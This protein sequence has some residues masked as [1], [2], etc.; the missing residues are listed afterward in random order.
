V[1]ALPGDTIEITASAINGSE[2]FDGS[3][4]Y[5]VRESWGVAEVL[6]D[7]S[8]GS[9]GTKVARIV[10][11]TDRQ[12]TKI[13]IRDCSYRYQVAARNI[14]AEG[15]S[16][17][18][19]EA[20][21]ENIDGVIVETLN[22]N[23]A[24]GWQDIS[25]E[26]PTGDGLNTIYT[27]YIVE[28]NGSTFGAEYT[29]AGD[30]ILVTNRNTK[31][32]I[33]KTWFGADGVTDLTDSITD[34]TVSLKVY[35]RVYPP[36]RGAYTGEGSLNVLTGDN[37]VYGYPESYDN[38]RQ[39]TSANLR[40]TYQNIKAGSD[41]R[42]TISS[43]GQYNTDPQKDEIRINGQEV[44]FDYE[45]RNTAPYYIR[46]LT[47][48][49]VEEDIVFSGRI[50]A[51]PF[52]PV[53]ILIEVLSEPI[54]PELLATIEAGEASLS[55]E[56]F[57]FVPKEPFS[58]SGITASAGQDVWTGLINNLPAAGTYNGQS[59]EYAYYFEEIVGE[60]DPYTLMETLDE[61]STG[62]VV[63]LKNKLK[64]GSLKVTKAV[65]PALGRG[66]R[67]RRPHPQSILC[68]RWV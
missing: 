36:S 67:C 52:H 50:A 45:N 11:P 18:L 53:N 19:S 47:L 54:D 5:W 59:V 12:A 20:E 28:E 46:T 6:F 1:T 26:Y 57:T 42:I 48:E 40:G 35:Q 65:C 23:A 27:Y 55:A 14:S 66:S 44:T 7:F 17:I 22:L 41:L 33:D 24:N 2:T 56:S 64:P 21:A 4:R 63:R 37:F 16:Q 8:E 15:R 61:V 58:G 51:D 32:E 38:D 3:G 34:K 68:I 31:V 13:E 39:L 30:S 60:N 10:L 25:R 9:N 49:N 43:D 29:F 62:G